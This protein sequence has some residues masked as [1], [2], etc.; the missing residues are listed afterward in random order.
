MTRC[1]VDEVRK[2]PL[3]V[4]F[5]FFLAPSIGELLSGSSPPVEFFNP[6]IILLLGAL[7][8]SGAILVRELRVR[9]NKGWLTVLILGAAYGIIEEGWMV[10]SFFDPA[11]SDLGPLGVYGRWAGVNW[12]WSL[13]LTVFHAVFSISIPILLVEML[14]PARRDKAWLSR[15]GMTGFTTLLLADVVFGF[16]ALTPYRPPALQYI[17]SILAALALIFIASR[18]P[19]PTT[20]T[21]EAA[22]PQPYRLAL[23]GFAATLALFFCLWALPNTALPAWLTMLLM[24]LVATL[25]WQG[26]AHLSRRAALTDAHHLA[27]ASGAL[28]FFIILA[29][30]QEMDQMRAD[31]TAGMALVGLAFVVLLFWLF[32]SIQKRA[33][34][35]VVVVQT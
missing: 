22:P 29:P 28:S 19:K 6:F 15:K 24:A 33:A 30:L 21:G 4:W 17:L 2:S 13:G 26:I 10:K 35:P 11:W 1:A 5:L 7:Y 14:F 20:S 32:R 34:Q 25:P 9:W 18:L 3:P 31:N 23:S 12:V 16:L 8:G 27:L